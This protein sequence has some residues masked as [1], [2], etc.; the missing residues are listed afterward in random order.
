MRFTR[1]GET[2]MASKGILGM[3]VDKEV[4]LILD[5]GDLTIANG[6]GVIKASGTLYQNDPDRIDE[7]TMFV[8]GW[9]ASITFNVNKAQALLKFDKHGEPEDITI[10]ILPLEEF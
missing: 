1:I 10:T 9:D 5:L 8:E 7:Y 3:F 4:N 6:Q 2:N